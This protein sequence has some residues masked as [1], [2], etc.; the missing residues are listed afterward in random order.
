M[1]RAA[2]GMVAAVANISACLSDTS[3]FE[4]QGANSRPLAVHAVIM[5]ELMFRVS[6]TLERCALDAAIPKQA[7][8]E[9]KSDVDWFS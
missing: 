5:A 9:G 1:A 2:S 7:A 3:A 8:L 4:T 6:C